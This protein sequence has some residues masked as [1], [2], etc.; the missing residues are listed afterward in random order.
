MAIQKIEELY[1]SVQAHGDVYQGDEKNQ[2]YSIN[3]LI[4]AGEVITIIDTD[5]INKIEL[6]GGLII[7]SSLVIADEIVLTLSNGATVNIRGA[8]SFTYNV[9]MN[10]G[11][12]DNTGQ[13]QTFDEF[14]VNSLGLS[15]TP[16]PSDKPVSGDENIIINDDGTV[17][18]LD[19]TNTFLLT[20]NIDGANVA[21][22]LFDDTYIA[23]NL[24]FNSLD[25]VNA[26]DG[27]DT[28]TL[29]DLN[30]LGTN[31][32]NTVVDTTVSSIEILNFQS[33][34]TN[35][36]L[37]V[38]S[39]TGLTALN[40]SSVKGSTLTAAATTNITEVNS[41]E[42][43]SIIGGKDVTI[44][45]SIAGNVVIDSAAGAV[46]VTSM[47]NSDVLI[48]GNNLDGDATTD[49]KV[50]GAIT[51]SSEGDDANMT[52]A[53][54]ITGGTTI[55]V[56]ASAAISLADRIAN[57]QNQ[58]LT[59]IIK[60]NAINANAIADNLLVNI[61][62]LA[63]ELAADTGDSIAEV[64]ELTAISLIN[65][66][67]ITQA[68]KVSIDSAFYKGHRYTVGTRDEK[69]VAAQTA[70]AAAMT[71]IIAD[72]TA[73]AAT[74]QTALN[75]ATTAND[76]AIIITDLDTAAAAKT[77]EV[78]VTAINNEALT[79]AIV[80]GNYS[81]V[82]NQIID[83]STA[84]DKLTTVTLDNA[85]TFALTGSALTTVNLSHMVSPTTINNETAD[86]TLAVNFDTV[87]T[88][89][90]VD[91]VTGNTTTLNLDITG[92]N[93]ADLMADD[94]TVLNITGSGSLISAVALNHAAAIIDAST[95][96][97]SLTVKTT[98]GQEYKGGDGA[99]KVT[100]SANL[101][102]AK[103]DG[104]AG[105][106][107]TMVVINTANV[108]ITGAALY[109][110]FEILEVNNAT[111][112]VSQFTNSA[113]TSFVASGAA[114]TLNKVS[115]AQAETVS[116][117]GIGTQSLEIEV[118][119][120][121][122]GIQTMDLTTVNSVNLEG[123]L[124][125][126]GIEIINL[127]TTKN[128]LVEIDDLET[129][130][131]LT[132]LVVDGDSALILSTGAVV[133]A[134]NTV[135]D[136]STVTNTVTIDA[137]AS[138]GTGFEI[139]GSATQDNV[140]LSTNVNGQ[141]IA[142]TTIINGG[143]TKDI[144]TGGQ[145]NDIINAGEGDNV[146]DSGAGI[147]TITAG[148]GH[149]I[150]ISGAGVDT[151]TVGNGYNQITAG[152]GDDIITIGKGGAS[153]FTHPIRGYITGGADNDSIT[154]GNHVD[155]VISVVIQGGADSTAAT[156]KTTADDANIS[157]G[158]VYTFDDGVD[159]V[160]GFG[161]SQDDIIIGS[162]SGALESMVGV[163]ENTLIAET[164]LFASGAWD[165]V[166]G[167]FT[168]AADGTGDD[169]MIVDSANT[170]TVDIMANEGI[171]ILIGVDSDDLDIFNF[172]A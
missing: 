72:V 152:A 6:Q 159:T 84:G 63:A 169:T 97:G 70:T 1:T 29:S 138:Q 15:T 51:V 113:F 50:L 112:D 160:I 42:A 34:G 47:G 2:T 121:E 75:A 87:N 11:N 144:I 36:I 69:L 99:D 83:G 130:S 20:E 14:V 125:L 17:T 139:S 162:S 9:G 126:A 64:M 101:Q 148:N 74:T 59:A 79:S 4:V 38:S 156:A 43:V 45:H 140:L 3:P 7:A 118:I 132:N 153:D 135:L 5:G 81:S 80:T 163:Q 109:H 136:A 143:I 115:I 165:A 73:A 88:N 22:T 91:A 122:T 48:G 151:I 114:V 23:T 161:A 157:V 146:I 28:M 16:L 154:L 71:T 149:N 119:G 141:N 56:T 110:N 129:V 164:T 57:A 117:V 105:S 85:G 98:E 52:G 61:T 19:D 89:L 107:D 168:I 145:Y 108:A 66:G 41:V 111:V 131:A 172:T 123:N 120:S 104:G 147:N 137:S 158:D 128:G 76:A 155:G 62:A 142:T 103:I 13:A 35:S 102:T 166:T 116:I 54:S 55:D 92:N 95:A 134:E 100:S 82:G 127:H 49:D 65:D 24:T 106:A 18:P 33:I 26:S 90:T 53:V 10:F 39:W 96:T 25:N 46:T 124:T 133:F 77:A 31:F 67:E 86:N 170:G 171:L 60:N 32:T 27:I 8:S 44:A 93:T 30:T 167:E 12:G 21:G 94:V 37:D 78:V 58:D 68:Q 40:I 150:I